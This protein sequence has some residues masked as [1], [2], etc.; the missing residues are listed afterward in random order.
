MERREGKR[1]KGVK[2]KE[3]NE[4]RSRNEGIRLWNP[5]NCP[6]V[7]TMDRPLTNPITTGTD[8]NR[9]NLARV[10]VGDEE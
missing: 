6:M 1:K 8:T 7:I 3:E 10:M 2:G 9:M 4:W 5:S